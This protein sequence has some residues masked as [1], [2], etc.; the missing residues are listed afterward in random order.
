MGSQRWGDHHRLP[1]GRLKEKIMTDT[2]VS[3]PQSAPPKK[4]RKKYLNDGM[5]VPFIL[6][7]SCFAAWGM[8]TDMTA[9]LVKVF[10]SVFSMSTF[11]SS[12]VQF[13]YYGAYFLLAIPAAYINSKLG[14]KGGVCIGLF[15]AAAGAFAFYPASLS[16][17]FVAFIG[18]LFSL[19]AGLSILETSANPFVIAMGPE[20]TSTRRLNFAQSFNPIGSNL[21]VLVAAI[22]ILPNI[23]EHTAE[24]RASLPQEELT[25]MVSGELKAVMIP[26]VGLAILY[27]V[28]GIAIAL[29]KIPDRSRSA[30]DSTV[31]L[32]VPSSG[33]LGRLIRNRR[34]SF[35]VVAQF[36]NIGAQTCIWTYVIHYSTNVVGKT[37]AESGIWL[38]VSLICFLVARFVMTA[39]MGIIDARRLL[40]IM[41]SLGG[42]LT[43][44]GILA[45][46]II[47][48]I[49]IA[50]LSACISLLFPTIYGQALTGLGED[51]KFGSAGLVMAIVGGAIL[52]PVQ[53]LL[54]DTIGTAHSF[55]VVL[56]CFIVVLSYG[57]F[58]LRFKNPGETAPTAA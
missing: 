42:V 6:L 30:G 32:S 10:G 58:T 5:L 43:L 56:V 9:P 12:L 52:P 41:C 48:L 15:L 53:G 33:R 17:T 46:N 26:F 36:F 3:S 22:M 45:G 25:S 2:S 13:S 27:L 11:Q 8:S 1:D 19:A 28:L 24:E 50:S 57:V 54:V 23:H 49:A 47:G 18:A 16:M 29:V 39:L 44:V 31:A 55:I 40:I 38:Q 51:T 14:Y 35:G 37:N 21:G 7:V 4:E 34:Y 20:E